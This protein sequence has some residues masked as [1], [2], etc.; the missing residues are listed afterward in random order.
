MQTAPAAVRILIAED[1]A[2][3]ADLLQRYLTGRGHKV[4][5]TT[6]GRSA[7]RT[8][9]ACPFD[10]ALLDIEMPE[11]DGLE[12][13]KRVREEN[14][15]A[16]CIIITGHSTIDTAVAAVRLGA[17]D[18]LSKPYRMEEIDLLVRRACE[19]RR[20]TAE[21]R[22]LQERLSRGDVI[23]DMSSG[24]PPMRAAVAA[25]GRAA[26]GDSS[27]LIVGEPGSGRESMARLIHHASG[28][29][30]GPLVTV[31]CARASRG[32]GEGFLF[33]VERN[34]ERE[35][36]GA[37][38]EALG[39][40]EEAA[41]GTLVLQEVECLDDGVQVALAEA[42]VRGTYRRVGSRQRLDVEARLIATTAVDVESGPTR[43]LRSDLLASLSASVIAV[44]PL[45]ERTTD[46]ASLAQAFVNEVSRGR[47]IAIEPEALTALE[48]YNWPGNVHE[49]RNVIE[50]AVMLTNGG[51]IRVI[52]LSICMEGSASGHGADDA[53]SL[54][55]V[56]RAHIATVLR[57]AEWHQ[58]RAAAM[59]GISAKTLYRKIREY[60]FERPQSAAAE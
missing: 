32:A 40:I 4:T 2:R 36:H 39:H 27:V 28:R 55:T 11:L 54:E 17:Y 33:G 38:A 15:P 22:R 6:D 10:V 34:G 58:G 48:N 9:R 16:E 26:V 49:L 29:A 14:A 53:L 46:I 24:S 21:N 18:Y 52:D 35:P 43:P 60:G 31:N 59:L 47:N 57:Q 41:S 23:R 50:R 30:S 45:R 7:L 1:E 42:I 56:E 13:L 3:L 51:W 19:K 44:P 37:A 25:A 20:M 5:V 12:V 8:L